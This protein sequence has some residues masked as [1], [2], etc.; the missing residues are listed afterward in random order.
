MRSLGE[1]VEE[2]VDL[3]QSDDY[4]SLRSSSESEEDDAPAD[5]AKNAPSAKPKS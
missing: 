4:A 1:G 2:K 3:D 5:E